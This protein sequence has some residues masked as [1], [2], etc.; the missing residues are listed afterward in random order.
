MWG[1]NQEDLQ[2]ESMT[3]SLEK[4]VHDSKMQVGMDESRD[5]LK[6]KKQTNR[7]TQGGKYDSHGP[8]GRSDR[9]TRSFE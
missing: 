1:N 5:V 9:N 7:E 8:F 6:E 2:Q 3:M 4:N